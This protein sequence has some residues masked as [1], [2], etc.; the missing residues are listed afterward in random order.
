MADI[1]TNLIG[2]LL[3]QGHEVGIHGL[4]HEYLTGLPFSRQKNHIARIR[5]E[6]GV[7]IKGANFI[8]RMD[9]TTVQALADN[10]IEYFVYPAINIYRYFAYTR[11]LPPPMRIK[12]QT[13][14]IYALPITMET[15]GLPLFSV[16]N[17]AKT[18]CAAAKRS[19]F[20]H[21]SVLCHPFRDGSIKR[22]SSLIKLTK[23]F[24]DNNREAVT[25][26]ELITRLKEKNDNGSSEIHGTF[27]M[28]DR[29]IPG[30]HGIHMPKH[31]RD[32]LFMPIESSLHFLRRFQK[33]RTIF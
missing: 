33:G 2:H 31:E 3:N 9:N 4:Y 24:T 5:D 6:L 12:S 10:K 14:C 8:G 26:T 16:Y 11:G 15:Y 21:I 19:A 30:L 18:L 13:G 32:L 23:L 29:R 1:Y 22:I 20:N 17:I 25:L 28:D 27:P 7:P